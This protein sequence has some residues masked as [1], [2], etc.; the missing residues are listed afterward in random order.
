MLAIVIGLLFT[1]A[2]DLPFIASQ[3]TASLIVWRGIK[4]RSIVCSAEAA[5]ERRSPDFHSCPAAA[6]GL[7]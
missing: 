6:A 2:L 1:F 5:D 3:R 7:R 4:G